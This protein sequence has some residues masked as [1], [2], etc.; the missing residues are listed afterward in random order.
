MSVQAL[1]AALKIQG[2]TPAEKLLLIVLANYADDKMTCWPSHSTLHANTCISER[3]ILRLLRT[4]EAKGLV[5]RKARATRNG[6]RSS[7]LIR[8]DLVGT[9]RPHS[10]SASGD[11]TSPALGT[12]C[13]ISGDMVSDEP[14]EN[15]QLK[16]ARAGAS[17]SA[18]SRPTREEREAGVREAR[19]LIAKL[20]AGR[21]L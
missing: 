11:T 10:V 6:R 18:R 7:D 15:H 17:H 9:P 4:L 3:N 8:L 14:K 12:P 20:T 16:D 2:V 1:T 21:G 19:A 5:Y 13:P